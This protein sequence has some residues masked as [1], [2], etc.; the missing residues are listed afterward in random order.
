M[1]YNKPTFTDGIF[2]AF[3]LFIS[4]FLN[5]SLQQIFHTRSLIP[6]VFVLGVFLISWRTPGYFW[7]V[8]ASL[9]SV[10]AVNYTFTYP[11]WAFDLI[12]PEC[13]FSAFVMLVV[14]IMTSTLTTRIKLQEKIRS[15]METERMRSNLLRAVSHDLRT[16]LTSIYGASST[17]I[18]N[19]DILTRDQTLKLLGEVQDDAQWLIRMVENL[20]SVTRLD[21]GNMKINKSPA[22]LE[23]LIDM[24][25]VKFRKQQPDAPLEVN[26]PDEFLTIPMDNMLIQQVLLNLLE[27]AVYHAKGMT[28][29]SLNVTL[30][31]DKV[32]FQVS[33]NGCGIPADRMKNLFTGYLEAKESPSDGTRHNTGIGLSVCSAIVKA[34][35]SRI[36]AK[37]N[38]TGGASF[39]FYLDLEDKNEQQ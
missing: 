14:S 3:I 18:E 9:I 12:S 24:V 35:G 31:E 5:L 6:M 1:K 15:E 20:L 22:V 13:I 28:C 2:T 29:L 23:E 33:D 26:I 36:I 34:H 30:L 17:I 37:N 38:P 10:L 25:L 7:G 11:Y 8:T 16:P 39:L 19:Y 21:A 27:N 4:F 32:M